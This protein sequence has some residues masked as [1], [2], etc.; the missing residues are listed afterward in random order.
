MEE[1]AAKAAPPTPTFRVHDFSNDDFKVNQDQQPS[2]PQGGIEQR[3]RKSGPAFDTSLEEHVI[4]QVCSN[5]ETFSH[6]VFFLLITVCNIVSLETLE[7]TEH[8]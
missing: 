7:E 5:F 6:F 3:R 8:K 1:C 4:H 2:P